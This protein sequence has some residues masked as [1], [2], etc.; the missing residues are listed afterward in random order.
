MKNLIYIFTI[1]IIIALTFASC[2][3]KSNNV[4]T[5]TCIHNNLLELAETPSTC[6]EHGYTSGLKCYDC[7]KITLAQT[8]K[9]LLDHRLQT[10]P[11]REPTCS[12]NGATEGKRCIMCLQFIEPF[13][14]IPKLPHTYTDDF[15]INCNACGFERDVDCEISSE[16]LEFVSNGDGTCYVSGIGSCT[17]TEIV[18]PPISPE[19]DT[20]IAIG[21]LGLDTETNP[22]V[23]YAFAECTTITS[24]KIPDTVMVIGDYA[25]GQCTALEQI[26]LPK[27][28]T[29]IGLG[30]FSLCS[31][32]ASI[33]IPDSV[34]NINEYSFYLCSSLVC[35]AVN[36]NNTKYTSINGNL[37]TKDKKTFIQ[38]AIG[39]TSPNFVIP[40]DVTNIGA[41]AFLGCPNIEIIELSDNVISIGNEAFFFCARLKSVTIPASVTSIGFGAFYACMSLECIE[42]D[43]NNPNYSSIDGSLYTKD[44]KTLIKYTIKNKD[45]SFTI[46]KSV[47]SIGDYA[48]FMVGNL[49]NISIPDSVTSI[50]NRAFY[51][52]TSLT[53]IVIP[54]NVTII[55][56]DAFYYCTSLKDVYYT[57]SE[58]VWAEI[59]IGS[60]NEYLSNATIHYNYVPE[61]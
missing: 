39:K 46:P 8:E 41:C 20:V 3:D 15:D 10:V 44:K 6:T 28:V 23:D 9:P 36:E 34:T 11:S 21:V 37:Y 59:S 22:P 50:G 48:F 43:K 38:Y 53:S 55:G 56:N 57:G 4:D 2:E 33:E 60:G 54:D 30:A 51:F 61:E 32:L 31:S 24:V 13:T 16:G 7:G 49:E 14:N 26:E 18:I 5:E 19:G 1:C 42:V 27:S 29:T 45:S 35:I 47:T 58:A 25:F 40:D 17:D 12:A 52:C